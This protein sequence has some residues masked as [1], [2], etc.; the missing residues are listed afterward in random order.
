MFYGNF[1]DPADQALMQTMMETLPRIFG[2]RSH[3]GDNNLLVGK[4]LSYFDD[5]RFA[6]A[7]QRQARNDQERS[8]SVRMNTLVW[9]FDNALHLDGDIVECGVWRGFSFAFL[10]D[11]FDF[12]AAPRTLWLYDTFDG[13]PP[14][15]DPEGHDAADYHEAGL[16]ESVLARFA[17][18]PNVK[19]VQ[20]LLPA[21]LEGA[22]PERI[23]LLHLDLNSSKGEIETLDVL[24]DR[25]VPGGMVVFDDYGWAAYESQHRAEKAWAAERGYRILETP[26]GQGVLLKR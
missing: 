21:S 20:G 25:I 19:V 15:Y 17:A 2:G 12:A 4:V 8:L 7:M 23:A 9:A 16:H 24:F 10:T 26:N 6:E 1:S 3:F 22:S 11:Y 14:A 18:F 13:I 5:P